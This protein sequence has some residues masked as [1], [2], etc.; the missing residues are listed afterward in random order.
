MSTITQEQLE[1]YL[2]LKEAGRER[3]K[4]RKELLDLIDEGAEVEAGL[5]TIQIRMHKVPW[6]V[7]AGF[8]GHVASL[9]EPKEVPHL[10]VRKIE[11]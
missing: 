4:L 7:A 11:E 2:K 3:L 9:P 10:I 1:K 6:P 5:H 8:D